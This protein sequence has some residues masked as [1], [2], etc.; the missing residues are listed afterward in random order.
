VLSHVAS[1]YNVPL[2]LEQQGCLTQLYRILEIDAR[3]PAAVFLSKGPEHL[4][5]G[6][7]PYPLVRNMFMKR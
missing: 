2:L 4:E 6:G 5:K 1:T 7:R 3:Y